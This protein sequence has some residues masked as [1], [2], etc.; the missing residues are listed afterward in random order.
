MQYFHGIS[1]ATFL[2]FSPPVAF[3]L[4]QRAQT[5]RNEKFQIL[6][7]KCHACGNW[8]AV[9]G[10]KCVE[11]KVSSPSRYGSFGFAVVCARGGQR[12]GGDIERVDDGERKRRLLGLGKHTVIDGWR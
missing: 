3:R 4:Q 6:E 7:G 2:P 1:P 11:A 5:Y 9:E 10:I 8:A 12:D